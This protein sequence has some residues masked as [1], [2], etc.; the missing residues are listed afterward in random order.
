[1]CKVVFTKRKRLIIKCVVLFLMFL[2][3]IKVYFT[4]D[5]YYY[6]KSIEKMENKG[7]LVTNELVVNQHKVL[8]QDGYKIHYVYN[9]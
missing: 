4:V 2:S 3:A 6:E 5:N 9:W 1:M 8:E 7:H